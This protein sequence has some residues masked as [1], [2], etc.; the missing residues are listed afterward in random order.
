MATQFVPL[1][2]IACGIVERIKSGAGNRFKL[3]T[4]AQATNGEQVWELLQAMSSI[5]GCI[6]TIG[7]G[8]FG[9][10]TLTRTVRVMVIVVN[11]FSRGTAAAA[12]GIWQQVESVMNLFLPGE[13]TVCPEVCGIVFM[14]VTWQPLESEESVCAYSLVLEGTEFLTKE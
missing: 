10:D 14:P 3:V 2:E 8:E 13:Q 5:P 11:K 7:S 1:R 9:P 6:V 12:D 4:Y